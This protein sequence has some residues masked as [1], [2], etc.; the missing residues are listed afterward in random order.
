MTLTLRTL[1]AKLTN[2]A[3][4]D[5]AKALMLVD[6]LM[7]EYGFTRHPLT[8]EAE[9]FSNGLRRL[10]AEWVTAACTEKDGS[11]TVKVEH[12]EGEPK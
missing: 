7:R 8:W 5:D 1:V 4:K 3:H 2:D 10:V 12:F 9:Q 11:G 6:I